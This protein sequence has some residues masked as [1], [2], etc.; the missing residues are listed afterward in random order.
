MQ[1]YH[2]DGKIIDSDTNGIIKEPAFIIDANNWKLMKLGEK[3]KLLNFLENLPKESSVLLL[4]PNS[5]MFTLDECVNFLNNLIL[6]KNDTRFQIMCFIQ[7]GM[8]NNEVSK[9]RIE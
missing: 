6:N 1:F 9:K 4:V 3:D 5:D 7:K 2:R 8:K